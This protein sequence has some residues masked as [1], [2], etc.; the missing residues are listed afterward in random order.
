MSLFSKL[1]GK[2]RRSER[3][4][5]PEWLG[6]DE[7]ERPDI[8]YILANGTEFCASPV[9][10]SERPTLIQ[11]S[12]EGDL[13]ESVEYRIRRIVPD[14][15]EPSDW[16]PLHLKRVAPEPEDED[17]DG[18]FS[19]E[20]SLHLSR[21]K[22]RAD[23]R[24]CT[25]GREAEE[26]GSITLIVADAEDFDLWRGPLENWTRKSLKIGLPQLWRSP[27]HCST[28]EMVGVLT[29]RSDSKWRPL[30]A[31]Q[32]SLLVATR[33]AELNGPGRWT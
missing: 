17:Q 22:Y 21:G 18:E 32:A 6:Y 30:V 29:M 15:E 33:L 13:P 4:Q 31:I 7:G 8:E 1:F 26:C 10:G 12:C 14:P 3:R 23:L 27:G 20:A 2:D 24:V 19:Y 16:K 25:K 28:S 9:D 5:R 11:A